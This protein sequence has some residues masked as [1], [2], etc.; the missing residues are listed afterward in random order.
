VP[1]WLARG[2][3]ALL[4]GDPG[5]GKSTLAAELAARISRG[6]GQQPPAS[7]L[8]LSAEDDPARVIRPRLEAAGADLQRILLLESVGEEERPVQLPEDCATLDEIIEREQVAL[9]IIDPLMAFLGRGV[10]ASSDAHVR[11]ALHRLKRLAEKHQCAI[12]IIRHLTKAS[13]LPALYRGGGSIGILGA[14]RLAWIVGKDPA[15]ET[16]RVLAMNKSN[17]GPPPKSLRYRLEQTGDVCRLAWAGEC[18]WSAEEI[19]RP[20]SE[21]KVKEL[22]RVEEC[23]KWLGELLAN[24]PMLTMDLELQAAL[25]EFS[26]T[27]VKRARNRLGVETGRRGYAWEVWLPAKQDAAGTE[28]AQVGHS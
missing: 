23:A 13:H 15:D 26:Q 16:A 25:A 24:G 17:L 27:T 6:D 22:S 18:G 4:D 19:L 20:M 3:L 2:V 28:G 12:L 9:V 5:L 8:I 7:V 1:A 11:R 21:E 10:N 14:C